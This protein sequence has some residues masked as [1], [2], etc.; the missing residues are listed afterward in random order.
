MDISSVIP[1]S[2][3]VA[4]INSQRVVFSPVAPANTDNVSISLPG[5]LLSA[6]TIFEAALSNTTQ[7]DFS[8]V[9][10]ATQYFAD[11]FNNFLQSGNLQS[12]TGGALDNLFMQALNT[13]SG[14][15]AAIVSSLSAIGINFQTSTSLNGPMSVNFN[16]LQSAFNTNPTRTVSLLAQATLSIGQ[17]AA[18]FTALAAQLNNLTQTPQ[19]LPETATT[20]ATPAATTT[21]ATAPSTAATSIVSSVATTPA[22]T[23]PATTP[24][25]TAL[26]ATTTAPIVTTAPA[27]STPATTKIA[28]NATNQVNPIINSADPAVAAAIASYH[29]VDGI[30]DMARPHNEGFAPKTPGYSEIGPVAPIRPLALNLHA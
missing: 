5:Q 7:T 16:T 11:A 30:F 28:P 2:S 3:V 29:M 23:T 12:T 4:I 19:V 1:P 15:E 21:S 17:L 9:S 8:T 27:I 24:T 6:S 10:V 25:N 20:N 18:E 26:T 13:G 14:N 22:T